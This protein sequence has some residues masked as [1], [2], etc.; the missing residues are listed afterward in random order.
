MDGSP[1]LACACA[2]VCVCFLSRNH[3]G[4]GISTFL[5]HSGGHQHL[6]LLNPKLKVKMTG[7]TLSVWNS[8][9]L[10]PGTQ[11]VYL[12]LRNSHKILTCFDCGYRATILNI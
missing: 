5:I 8:G 6:L 10:G 12:T 11:P 7:S 9:P 3:H 4:K 1:V 2:G